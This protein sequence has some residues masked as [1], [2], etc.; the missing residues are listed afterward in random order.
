MVLRRKQGC[1]IAIFCYS[2]QHQAFLL[3]HTLR[4]EHAVGTLALQPPHSYC[5]SSP[6]QYLVRCVD[7][8]GT[9]TLPVQR[10]AHEEPH[11]LPSLHSRHMYMV[12]HS[13]F[14][15]FVNADGTLAP[16]SPIEIPSTA[17]Q[18]HP[19]CLEFWNYFLLT[20][21]ATDA[22]V[23]TV[24]VACVSLLERRVVAT[25]ATHVPAQELQHVQMYHDR[26]S[27]L[28]A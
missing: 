27:D 19:S 17:V 15:I 12:T 14:G 16:T 6:E 21:G 5:F 26:C 8:G 4:L 18:L 7:S 13:N 28:T 3:T 25:T 10:T 22:P 2:T 1:R 23:P 24:E 11:T 20:V 9:A